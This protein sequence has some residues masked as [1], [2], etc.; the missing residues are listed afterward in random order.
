MIR[1]G[2]EARGRK[3]FEQRLDELEEED[4]AAG[5][6]VPNGRD[7]RRRRPVVAITQCGNQDTPAVK[8]RAASPNRQLSRFSLRLHTCN[9]VSPDGSEFAAA[10]LRNPRLLDGD[11]RCRRH[12]GGCLRQQLSCCP[13]GQ[14]HS[15][16]IPA[17]L[18]SVVQRLP[19]I[20][21]NLANASGVPPPISLPGPT[22][23]SRMSGVASALL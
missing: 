1:S 18:T 23:L 20:S 14:P 13:R 10:P 4:R 5:R 15:T 3:E 21:M 22:I 6:A 11:R 12:L 8:P 16:L 19:S 17:A 7:L 2:L 9:K